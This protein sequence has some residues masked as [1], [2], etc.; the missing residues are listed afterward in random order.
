MYYFQLENGNED[1]CPVCDL[2]PQGF[3]VCPHSMMGQTFTLAPVEISFSPE[4][5]LRGPNVHPWLI[6]YITCE[7]EVADEVVAL[8]G[9]DASVRHSTEIS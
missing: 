2:Y 9:T 3:S 5:L 7:L 8:D 4:D 1:L 6:L